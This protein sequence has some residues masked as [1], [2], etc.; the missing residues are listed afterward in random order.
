MQIEFT[1]GTDTDVYRLEV[2]SWVLG[3]AVHFRFPTCDVGIC[4]W[5]IP[6]DVW[7]RLKIVNG[8]GGAWP[9]R[10]TLSIST[11]T[12]GAPVTHAPPVDADFAD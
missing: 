12:F 5:K 3:Y 7:Q 4:R 8:T 2:V 9:A 11:G 10:F 1:G 6:D